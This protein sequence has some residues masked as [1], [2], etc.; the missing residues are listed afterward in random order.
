M[1]AALKKPKKKKHLRS[2][3]V[4]DHG[5]GQANLVLAKPDSRAEC[6]QSCGNTHWPHAPMVLTV[7]S[8][9]EKQQIS[10]P[11]LADESRKQNHREMFG[12]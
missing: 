1:G 2:S 6:R 7:L 11:H 10:D 3:Q 12:S 4:Q 9:W 5:E 8:L